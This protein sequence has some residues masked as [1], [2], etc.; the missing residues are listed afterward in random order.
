VLTW[1]QALLK[2]Q[3]DGLSVMRDWNRVAS[4]NGELVGHKALAV[5]QLLET[6][7][8][9]GLDLLLKH[10][11]EYGWEAS[12]FT[13]DAL[14]S[15][16]LLPNQSFRTT[17]GKEWSRRARTCNESCV[18]AVEYMIKKFEATPQRLRVKPPKGAWEDAWVREAVII[19]PVQGCFFRSMMHVLFS[20]DWRK[21]S[22]SVSRTSLGSC[23]LPLCT[24]GMFPGPPAL[25][26]Q[27]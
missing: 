16:K 9:K 8:R 26:F 11:S 25:D 1:I 15:K 18:M 10:V 21:G 6:F 5:K 7:P 17:G 20:R 27:K 24:D 2:S 4:E 3:E 19:A 14:G 22:G 12:A 13:E 23:G